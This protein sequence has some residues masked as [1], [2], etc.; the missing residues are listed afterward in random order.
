MKRKII[1]QGHNTLTITLPSDWVKKL[2]LSAGNEIDIS[3]RDNGLFLTAEK[4]NQTKKI[5]LDITGMDIPT[6]WKYF[7]GIYR[8]GYDDVLIK[9]SPEME[10][11]NP[12]KFFSEHKLD[13]RYKKQRE[14]RRIFEV[15]QGFVDRFIGFE[16]VEHGKDFIRIKEMGEVTSREFDNS[17]R[18]VFYLI[19]QMV[20]ET[21]EA[22]DTNNPRI[23]QHMH[24]VDINLDK[25]H[26]YCIRI[27]NKV[28]NKDTK[29]TSLF[30]ATLYILELLG[31]EF[32][33][34]SFH[35]IEDYPNTKLK[36]MKTLTNYVKEQFEIYYEL[37]YK[38]DISKVEK[39]VE[40]DK[41]IYLNIGDF[42]KGTTDAEKEIF[43]HLRL[44]GRYI[45]A[46][47]ELRIEMEF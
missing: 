38:F 11:E 22:I 19:E 1:K 15:L 39:A 40:I 18:R 7:M 29:K 13:L 45:N 47:V 6:I 32:K 17:L 4:R 41:K 16:I 25:F 28:S 2:N 10:L 26:D 14:K 3:E 12:Y 24:D 43:H 33:H 37:F 35:L 20:E 42:Y 27:L 34:I 46:L 8:E 31:D 23:L 44:I 36:H 5:E 21:Y 30:F 9:F